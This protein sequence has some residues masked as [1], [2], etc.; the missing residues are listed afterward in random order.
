M[1]MNQ[2][3]AILAVA[4]VAA[5][6]TTNLSPA[7][8]FT[9]DDVWNTVKQAVSSD[10][11]QQQPSSVNEAPQPDPAPQNNFAES[12][13]PSAQSS[14]IASAL[15]LSCVKA[16]GDDATGIGR[17]DS[18]AMISVGRNAIKVHGKVYISPENPHGGTCEIQGHPSSEKV[19][20]GYAIPDNSALENVRVSIYVDGQERI[21]KI[22]SRGQFRRYVFDI[23]GASSY[24]YVLQPLDS[25]G[26]IYFPHTQKPN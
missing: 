23:T 3:R 18:D 25:I 20:L 22:I 26:E 15:Q 2:F 13:F 24:A 5:S 8:A 4:V 12:S 19:A 6:I 10:S 21:S 1:K 9:W 17:D 16:N 7:Q 14:T 11:P